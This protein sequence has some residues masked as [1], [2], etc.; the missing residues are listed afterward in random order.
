MQLPELHR[1]TLLRRYKRFLADVELPDG[2]VV[3]AHCGN[4]G[5]MTSC[6]EPGWTV[7]LSHHDNPKRK[8]KWSWEL[9][10]TPEGTRVLV[11]TSRPNHVVHEALQAGLVP[12][13][14]GYQELRTEVRY[15][16]ERSR[17]DLLLQDPDRPD[18]YVEVKSVT[19]RV[20]PE[21]GAFPDAVSARGTKHLRELSAMV[22][23]GHRAVLFFL[24]GRADVSAVR[25]A[26]EIDPVY[27]AALADAMSSGVEVIAY[28]LAFQEQGLNLGPRCQVVD[29]ND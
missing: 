28:Q 13:L 25:A 10:Q 29:A 14:A 15:G 2:Q 16:A 7:W 1:G 8:L 5:R 11:N 9:S 18:C 27:A 22:A 12:E 6:A 24:V 3:T 26:H 20:G 21:L 17:I 4:P 19:L 23:Q